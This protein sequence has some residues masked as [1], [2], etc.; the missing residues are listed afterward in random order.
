MKTEA[1][2][3][4]KLVPIATS[5]VSAKD[6]FR[7]M[8]EISDRIAKRAYELFANR[9]FTNGRDLED[10]LTAQREL[11]K[12]VILDVKDTK[13]EFI[14]RAEV[15]GFEAKDLQIELDGTRLIIKGKQES[16]REEKENKGTTIFTE[17]TAKQIYRLI[18]LPSPV[19]AEK[20]VA[21][22]KNGVLELKLPKAA[23]STTIKL[24]AA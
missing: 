24:T 14:I 4:A 5:P 12:P 23:Q 9:G 15:P 7:E 19:L 21:D 1:T 18:D 13:Q 2:A 10:W 6:L 20:A 22:L 8:L 16:T 3:P 11:L 17:Q